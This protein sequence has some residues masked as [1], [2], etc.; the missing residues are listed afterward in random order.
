MY[1]RKPVTPPTLRLEQDGSSGFSPQT[2]DVAGNEANFFI[3]DATN[4]SKLPFRIRPNAPT[5][6]I[7]VA[8]DGNIGL[9]T[10]SPDEALDIVRSNSGGEVKIKMENSAN[11]GNTWALSAT[12]GAASSIGS[13]L[14]ISKQGTGTPEITINEHSDGNATGDA[15]LVVHGSIE[16]TNLTFT[17]SREKKMNFEAVD[18]NEILDSVASLEMASW[19]YKQGSTGK[20]IGP[21][22]ED[23]EQVFGLGT[24]GKT[25]SVVDASG[26]ALA[27]IQGLYK[28]VQKRDQEIKILAGQLANLQSQMDSISN[29][30]ENLP[31]LLQN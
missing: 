13:E 6:S 18:S 7:Y 12:D 2:W 16:A 14:R 20:H 4:G 30:T 28:E 9:G 21:I 17:S 10:A 8:A 29:S 24:N 23:F 1:T 22:A 3:R 27:A 15:T 25:I 26:I 31:S 5:D 19:Q 11:G